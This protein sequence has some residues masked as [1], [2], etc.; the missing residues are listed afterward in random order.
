MCQPVPG[1][2]ETGGK[3][4]LFPAFLALITPEVGTILPMLLVDEETGTETVVPRNIHL[5]TSGPDLTGLS[6]TCT[7]LL[8]LAWSL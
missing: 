5:V 4:K 8:R 6:P 3:C 2:G 1:T 7:L